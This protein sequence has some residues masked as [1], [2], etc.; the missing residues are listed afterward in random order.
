MK[1]TKRNWGRVAL[2]I[3]V[4]GAMVLSIAPFGARQAAAQGASRKIGDFD[5]AGRFLE[6]WQAQGSDQASTY[7]NGLP[8]TARRPEIS[9]VDGKTYATQWFE[10]AKFEAHPENKAPYDV[11]LGRLGANYVEGRGSIDPKTGKIRNPA[12]TPF[13]PI[14]K[15][16]NL[17]PTKIW[18]GVLNNNTLGHSISGKILEYWRRYGGGTDK[19]A[20]AQFGFALSEPYNEPSTDGKTYQVQYFERARFEVHPEKA[21]PYEVEIGLLGVQQY[22]ATPI[23]ADKLPIAPTSHN[24]ATAKGTH[25]QVTAKDTLVT[26]SAQINQIGSLF[27]I[28]ES[29]VVG[30]RILWAVTFQDS[31][32]GLDDQG[33]SFPLAAWLV[34]TILSGDSFFVNV[35]NDTHLVTKYKLRQGIKWSDGTLITSQ[36]A[37]FSHELILNDPNSVSISP[38]IKISYVVT[39]DPD[40]VVYHWMSLNEAIAKRNFLLANNPAA[41]ET[42]WSFLKTFIDNGLPVTDLAYEFVGTVHPAHKLQNIPVGSI[43]QSSEGQKPTGYGPYIVQEFTVGEIVTLVANPNYNLTDPPALNRIINRQVATPVQVQNYVAGAIDLIESEGTVVPPDDVQN[44]INAGGMVNSQPTTTFDRLEPRIA[45]AADGFAELGDLKTR[46][47]IYHAINRPQILN[48]A[49]HGASGIE[50]PVSPQVWHSLEHPNFATEFPTLALNYQL[51]EYHYDVAKAVQ[52]LQEAGWNC[53]AGTSG[54]NCGGQTRVNAQGKPLAF[55]YGTTSNNPV[56]LATQQLIKQD[57]AAV[58]VNADIQNYAGFFN[59]DGA[60]ATGIS[61]LSQF[62]YTSTSFSNFDP[63]DSSQ[64][65]TADTPSRQ[66]QQHYGNP[67]VDAANRFFSAQSTRAGIAEQS[68]IIQAEMTKDA[69]MLPLAVRQNIIMHNVKLMNVKPT[70]SSAP[71]YWNVTQW[72]FVP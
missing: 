24:Q 60:K 66:N 4:A 42:T 25:N 18:F 28:E 7:V 39:P 15:P 2:Y 11:L 26:G 52:L 61:E 43:A 1:E 41:L 51:T 5:V 23:A 48:T 6:V 56:R 62:A 31:L 58:G 27:G 10:R 49:W 69:A 34:P 38:H 17:G 57:L 40:T 32:V 54:N 63:Y 68:A 59:N 37:A 16:A 20:I 45:D 46:Q 14:A 29:T 70:N 9:T 3:S 12:D 33:T 35:G 64:W 21:P 13:L 44:L 30:Q 8:I 19:G 67:V 50:G 36:D 71:Q 22:R 65:N 47:G 72:Y 53:P 55:I